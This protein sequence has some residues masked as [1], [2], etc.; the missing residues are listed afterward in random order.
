MNNIINQLSQIEE[1]T[2]AILDGAADKKKTLAAEYEAKTKQ[3]DEELNHETELEIQS[4]RQKMEAEAAAELDRQKTAAGDQIAR[5]EQHYEEKHSWY[6]D[7]LFR[8]AV[9]YLKSSPAYRDVFSGVEN[10]EL[11]RSKIEELLWHSLYGDFSRLFRFANGTQRKF[12]DLYFL[13]FEIDVMKRCLRD[14]VS[15]K[16][17][18]LNFKSF[19]PFFRKHSHLDFTALT[20]S[21]DLDEYLD[22]IQNTPYY[23]PLKDLKDQGITSLSEFESALDILYFIRFWKS[24]KDQL[25]KDDREAI[26]DCA[27]EKIDLLNIE[28]LARAKRHYKLSADAIMELL[29]PVWHRLKKSQAREL[30]EAPSI[31]EFDRILKGTR[32]GNRIFRASGEQQ[33]NPELHSLFRALLDAVYSKSGRNDPYSAAALNSYFYF[34]EEEIRKI[35]TT[36]EGIRYSLGSS[37]ILT[38]LAE[39]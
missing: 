30:A 4:M 36:V 17:S 6:V 38:C 19:E 13:H 29:I 7:S 9:E 8:S 18:D 32:Y 33:E 34:K 5:L 31:E 15:G 26:A 28:W 14:A 16:R 22:S 37:E 39:S 2:V 27:G 23:G 25:S 3:F 10:E 24:L 20:D 12:L 35:I 11:H 21:K 1:K